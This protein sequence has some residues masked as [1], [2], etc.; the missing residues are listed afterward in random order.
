M[1]DL[2]FRV[3]RRTER[4]VRV[5]IEHRRLARR[6]VANAITALGRGW[7]DRR[8]DASKLIRQLELEPVE[9]ALADNTKCMVRNESQTV[10]GL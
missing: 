4:I 7:P 5:V 2:S 3:R 1:F 9:R 6:F 8:R 10:S